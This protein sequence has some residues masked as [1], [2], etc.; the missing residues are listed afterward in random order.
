MDQQ[1][2][3]K[4]L[5]YQNEDVIS[6]FTDM[7]DIGQPEAEDI[8]NETKKF[9][10]LSQVPDIF[11]PDELLIIDEMWHNFVLFTKDYH[12]FCLDNFGRFVHHQPA[13]Y[14]EK[15]AYREKKQIDAEA[16]TAEFNQ[17][18]ETMLS[19]TYDHLG[20]DTVVKWFGTYPQQYSPE[21][22]KSIRKY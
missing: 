22:I 12:L 2:L 15:Q 14:K 9:L 7:M 6:R 11:I 4:I 17:K 18:L 5:A 19:A 1:Q 13:T 20:Q 10:Y 21:N 3:S 16:T 8:F